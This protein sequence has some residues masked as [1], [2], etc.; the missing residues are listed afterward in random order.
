MKKN[1]RIVFFG[2]E[3]LCTGIEQ[4]TF[5]LLDALVKDNH[6]IVALFAI[7][8]HDRPD[9][10]TQALMT[11]AH[12]HG[13]NLYLNASS[14]QIVEVIKTTQADIGVLAAYGRMVNQVIIDSLK[15]GIVNIHPS[16]LPQWRGSTPIE[17]AI[18]SGQD[19]TGVSIMQ[20]VAAMDVGPVYK[21][22]EYSLNIA[23]TKEQLARELATIGAHLLSQHLLE[24]YDGTLVPKEQDDAHAT[25]CHKIQKSDG[26]LDT[27]KTAQEL[28]R[29]IRAYAGW[30]KSSLT[31]N[32]LNIIILK[33]H[34]TNNKVDTGKLIAKNNQLLLGCTEGS[35]EIMELQVAG[36][37]PTS[38]SAFINGYSSTISNKIT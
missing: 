22:R 34:A 33:A 25:Y 35:L 24:I 10:T 26:V 17:S 32:T 12:T 38:A 3:K 8:N 16:L 29:E 36:K 31:Y 2:N 5:L 21:Q 20:L 28:E 7:G 6:E 11:F 15:H 30:P 37:L 19:K 1:L 9:P 23:I 4:E 14:D 13:I 27:H 18:L